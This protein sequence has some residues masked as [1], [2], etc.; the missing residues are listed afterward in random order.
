[1]LCVVLVL[2]SKWQED[3]AASVEWVCIASLRSM[4]GFSPG[5]FR[6]G[7]APA[8]QLIVLQMC[9]TALHSVVS[10]LILVPCLFLPGSF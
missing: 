9:V 5:L 1:M 6:N 4:T 10:P 3:S 2:L 8:L 7:V